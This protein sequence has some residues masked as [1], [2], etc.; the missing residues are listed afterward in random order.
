[1]SSVGLQSAHC[2][3]SLQIR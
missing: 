3:C 2:D 1:M